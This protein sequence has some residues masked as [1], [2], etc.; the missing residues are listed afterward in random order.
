MIE[1]SNIK[2]ASYGPIMKE[3]GILNVTNMPA[4]LQH[5][6]PMRIT[7]MSGPGTAVD[8]LTMEY[9]TKNAEHAVIIRRNDSGILMCEY[10][11]PDDGS[12][13]TVTWCTHLHYLLVNRKD[14]VFFSKPGRYMVP[15]VPSEGVYCPVHVGEPLNNERNKSLRSVSPVK[16]ILGVR[17]TTDDDDIVIGYLRSD[18]IATT[19]LRNLFTDWA[20]GNLE[21]RRYYADT[22]CG[23]DKHRKLK[24]DKLSRFAQMFYPAMYGL[25]PPCIED[26]QGTSGSIEN[27]AEDA[28]EF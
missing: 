8:K 18:Q 10:C 3:A 12:T 9:N 13:S 28:P 26:F 23:G 4:M 15:M 16:I 25:C 21:N 27:P 1:R 14:T 5:E 24:N 22:E 20:I 17:D 19:D 2:L 11:T 6:G 7:D